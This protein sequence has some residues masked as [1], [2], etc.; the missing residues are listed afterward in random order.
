[1]PLG[2]QST[3]LTFPTTVYPLIVRGI[4][5]VVSVGEIKCC[6][7]QR[8]LDLGAR[9]CGCGTQWLRASTGG[10]VTRVRVTGLCVKGEMVRESEELAALRWNTAETGRLQKV[11]EEDMEGEG[12][13]CRCHVDWV[14]ETVDLGGRITPRPTASDEHGMKMTHQIKQN[15]GR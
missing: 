9:M 11:A 7:R 2:L 15:L 5:A 3:V 14:T 13:K 10:L 1:M 4:V 8:G 6:V 12:K